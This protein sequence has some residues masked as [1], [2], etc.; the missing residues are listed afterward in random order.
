MPDNLIQKIISLLIFG[1]IL[2]VIYLIAGIIIAALSAPG[3]FL[4]VVLV[5]LLLVF[6]AKL[7][8]VFGIT[9]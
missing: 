2:Y 4:T 7:I 1:V 6:L 3:I 9:L 8:K 5:I